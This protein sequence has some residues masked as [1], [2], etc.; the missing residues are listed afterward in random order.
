[1]NAVV[2]GGSGFLGSHL[3]DALT[4]R[5]CQVTIFDRMAS[6]YLRPT[7]RMIVG[8]ILD[9]EAV[10]KTLEGCDYAYHFAGLSDLDD[11]STQ[12]LETVRLNI[13]GTV[14]LLDAAV[15]SGVKR[16]I[17]AS[18]IYVYSALGGFY[19]C[20]KQA[21]ELYVEEYQ[22]CYGLDY[23]ILRHGTLYGPRADARNSIHRYLQQGLIDGKIQFT[24]SREDVREYI[25][26]R[27]AARLSVEI[28]S[29]EFRN[30]H[31]IVTGHSAMKATD[32]LNMVQEILN[33][34]VIVE[35][36]DT[37]SKAHY[38]VTPHSFVPRA[39]NKLVSTC[40]IDM[41]QGLLECLSE[42]Y[43]KLSPDQRGEKILV[44]GDARP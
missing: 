2:F 20:S 19:R 3:A 42:I 8:D 22:R 1:M 43:Q 7:Q 33:K 39:G 27:D 13:M 6:P 23:T 11:A 44:A 30:Q 25:H 35:F 16:F 15:R 5:G 9:R 37:P 18:T 41:G 4:D 29:D 36:V 32:L 14:L 24:G 17:Y 40:Y 21:G 31:I 10:L 12:P 26:V 34:N 38:V 28:L